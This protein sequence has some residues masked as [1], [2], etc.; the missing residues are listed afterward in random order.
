MTSELI[1][2]DGA[3]VQEEVGL[4]EALVVALVIATA[5]VCLPGPAGA[6]SI[7]DV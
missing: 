4:K 2:G 3:H 5:S 6:Q 7:G 1:R